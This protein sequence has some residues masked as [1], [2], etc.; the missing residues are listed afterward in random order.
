MAR[1]F[2]ANKSLLRPNCEPR[3]GLVTVLGY[4]GVYFVDDRTN[5]LN[6][7]RR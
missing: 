6:S 1:R 7:L 2:H 3:D 4:T 5:T